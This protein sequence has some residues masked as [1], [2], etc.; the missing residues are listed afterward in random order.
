MT[1]VGGCN[2]M[3]YANIDLNS[4]LRVVIYNRCSTE[5]LAQVDAL[6][7][8]V[9]YSRDYCIKRNWII[10]HQYV[11]AKSG[12]S[13]EH[14]YEYRKLYASLS[15]MDYDLVVVKSQDRLMRSDLEWNL[16]IRELLKTGKRLFFYID[17][18]LYN[19]EQ[20]HMVY[21][22]ISK[23]NE[24]QSVMLSEKI[25]DAH[26]K[27][28]EF[29]TGI[30]ICREMFG[31]DKVDTNVYK[32]NE[33]EADAIREAFEL[34]RGGM[35]FYRLAKYMYEKGYRSKGTSGTKSME[36]RMI[37]ATWW[38][39]GC[40]YNPKMH[41]TVVMHK[42][43]MNFWTKQ[44]EKVPES[45][46]IY[47]DNALPAIVSKEYQEETIQMLKDRS[48]KN[49]TGDRKLIRKH[50]Y[51]HKIFCKTCNCYYYRY[52]VK[53][54]TPNEL[55]NWRCSKKMNLGQNACNN[56]IIEETVL[57]E[58][59]DRKAKEKFS[60]LFQKN[61]G[62]IDKAMKYIEIALND[63]S[64]EGILNNLEEEQRLQVRKKDILFNKL[65]D[66]TINDSDFK[67]YNEKLQREIDKLKDKID[68]LKGMRQSYNEYKAKLE[69]IRKV[70][71]SGTIERDAITMQLKNIIEKI[72]VEPSGHVTVI[73]D[74][75]K[76]VELLSLYNVGEMINMIDKNIFTLEFE[77][78]REQKRERIRRETNEKVLELFSKNPN[79]QVKDCAKML[80][81]K[82]SYI[83]TSVKQLREMGKLEHKK[84][85]F[86]TAIWIV[87][88]TENGADC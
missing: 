25:K 60:Q 61:T 55:T 4:R 51:S 83:C 54:G 17:S 37:S 79:L 1:K 48:Y 50:L 84:L 13:S 33:Q 46:W 62:I 35:G 74:T 58:L 12:T 65:I 47:Y 41:G 40:I 2:D 66:G 20:D 9:E 76:L 19:H 49:V 36:P 86:K 63:N 45:E 77:Y 81:M 16:F 75:D 73:F 53:K 82:Y 21:S 56:I 57:S 8:Q 43:S 67:E 5:E 24:F 64:S 32:I 88:R 29:K 78:H 14:R 42:D 34:V 38:K 7:R 28:Q 26:A 52:I 72:E 70:I 69:E 71:H 18:K 59:I 22:M 68:V 23:F 11:E 85:D 30:N 6:E 80:G 31:W 3:A 39:N 10:V 15:T 44:R 27:R 87:N